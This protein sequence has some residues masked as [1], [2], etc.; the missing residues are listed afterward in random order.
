MS[1]SVTGKVVGYGAA[2]SE[3]TRSEARVSRVVGCPQAVE[4]KVRVTVS[5][6][7][8]VRVRVRKEERRAAASSQCPSRCRYRAN[9]DVQLSTLCAALDVGGAVHKRAAVDDK[10][11]ESGGVAS[12]QLGV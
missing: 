8:R 5:L 7:V 3:R 9:G 4:G 6:A 12:E 1:G 11:T 10:P 2:S